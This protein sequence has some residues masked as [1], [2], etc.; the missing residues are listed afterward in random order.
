MIPVIQEIKSELTFA[1]LS[2]ISHT[3]QFSISLT[4]TQTK[5]RFLGAGYLIL[6]LFFL[7]HV[8]CEISVPHPEM[9]P[10]PTAVGA[11]S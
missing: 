5:Y 10:V 1:Y 11:Q 4:F 2:L 8:A 7:H 6:P 3:P 9:E